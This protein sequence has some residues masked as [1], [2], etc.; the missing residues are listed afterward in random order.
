MTK[1]K[2]P[3]K[4][5]EDGKEPKESGLATPTSITMQTSFIIKNADDSF[6][7]YHQ[8]MKKRKMGGGGHLDGSMGP[9]SGTMGAGGLGSDINYGVVHVSPSAR[10]GHSSDISRDGVLFVFGGDR[11]LMPFNDLYVMSL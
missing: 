3:S 4:K 10:D 11:H 1:G 8:Q 9:N 7:A 5:H 2:S 6:D